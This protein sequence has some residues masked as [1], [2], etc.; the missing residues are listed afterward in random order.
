MKS[1]EL[2]GALALGLLASL[3][4]HTAG[5]GD[6]AMGGAYH[7]LLVTLAGSAVGC[8]AL[9]L[10]A[11][12]WVGG[13]RFADGS[14]L[15]ARLTQRIPS[16]AAVVVSAAGWFALIE[17]LEGH[18]A[19]ASLF[20]VAIALAI[21]SYVLRAA[22]RIGARV[23]AAI[24]VAVRQRRFT[25]RLPARQRRR[26]QRVIAR[27]SPARRRHVARPPPGVLARA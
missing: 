23:I 20:L 7:A 18:P 10:G 5:Y 4:A 14:V 15:A 19:S 24:V 22:L 25:P 12:A 26:T 2:P 8:F 13:S 6:H 9:F 27:S 1:R 3:L 21:A 11:I 16:F 17:T